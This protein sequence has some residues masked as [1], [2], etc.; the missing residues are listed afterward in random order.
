MTAPAI[1]PDLELV[2]SQTIAG[3]TVKVWQHGGDTFSA[4][5]IDPKTREVVASSKQGLTEAEAV[6]FGT[7]YFFNRK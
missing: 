4:D 5:I 1:H 2:S 6:C 3:H 7:N